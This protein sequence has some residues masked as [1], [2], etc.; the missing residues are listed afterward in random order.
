MTICLLLTFTIQ[1]QVDTN[2][3]SLI[4]FP[5][6]VVKNIKKDLIK[7]DYCDSI[8]KSK[9]TIIIAFK[10]KIIAKDSVIKS[11]NEQISLYNKNKGLYEGIINVK[12]TEITA[13][14]KE[15][16]KQKFWKIVYKIGDFVLPVAAVF[17]T[18]KAVTK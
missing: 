8:S 7:G 14:N 15:I 17:F 2:K 11:R 12:N 1:S 18:Y 5:K 10:T 3:D 16:K 4:C 6:S 13:Q 9:D